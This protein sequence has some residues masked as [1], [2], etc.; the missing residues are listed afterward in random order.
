MESKRA[1]AMCIYN[2]S[3]RSTTVSGTVQALSL[4]GERHRVHIC[5]PRSPS[6]APRRTDTRT[7]L[8]RAC[9]PAT[10]PSPPQHRCAPAQVHSPTSP[11]RPFASH[12]G[13]PWRLT[14]VWRAGIAMSV[15]RT[16]TVVLLGLLLCG[17]CVHVVSASCADFPDVP[18]CWDSPG[19]GPWETWGEWMECIQPTS[20]CTD[21]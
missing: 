20:T 8:L 12:R 11:I 1:D 5:T 21:L 15:L 16:S 6:V 9:S 2:P 7:R 17:G 4:R 14:G 3:A 19:S 13:P 18:T 10:P